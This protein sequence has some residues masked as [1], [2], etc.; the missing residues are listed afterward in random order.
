MA[1]RPAGTERRDAPDGVPMRTPR[2]AFALAALALR[3][4]VASPTA[5]RV[6]RDAARYALAP[7]AIRLVADIPPTTITT[8]T[9]TTTTASTTTM[10]PAPP[11]ARAAAAPVAQDL[12]GRAIAA[13]QSAVPARWLGA[14]SPSVVIIPGVT[15]WSVTD[16]RIKMARYHGGGPWLRL[17]AVIAH[18]WGHQA[19]FRYGTNAYPGAPPTGWPY[20]GAGPAEAWAD[21]VAKALT[22]MNPH[23]NDT[24]VGEPLDFVAR[25]IAAGP[26]R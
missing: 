1:V 26:P 23:R 13:L 10:S 14:V 3:A 11:P 5:P 9:T 18:E 17:R 4:I 22:G 24:C 12:T 25:W 21:C 16:G 19:A 7:N 15:S 8:S 6:D 2:I 20:N